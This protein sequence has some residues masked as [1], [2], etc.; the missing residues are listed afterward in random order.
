MAQ[1][2]GT[3]AGHILACI[4]VINMVKKPEKPKFEVFEP[5]TR[6]NETPQIAFHC[7]NEGFRTSAYGKEIQ[8]II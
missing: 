3:M 5:K 7:V 2:Y 8:V 6:R 4:Y 1:W